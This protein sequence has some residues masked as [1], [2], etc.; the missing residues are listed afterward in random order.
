MHQRGEVGRSVAGV[1][2]RCAAAVLFWGVLLLGGVT[3]PASAQD[4]FPDTAPV[5]DKDILEEIRR[6]AEISDDTGEEEDIDEL[7]RLFKEGERAYT[8]GRFQDAVEFFAAVKDQTT[9]RGII[10]ALFW[11]MATCYNRMG[12]DDLERIYWR[13]FLKYGPSEKDARVARTRLAALRGAPG[14]SPEDEAPTPDVGPEPG[15]A[16]GGQAPPPAPAEGPEPER[17]TG[18]DFWGGP[19][20]QPE[21]PPATDDEPFPAGLEY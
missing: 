14:P 12:K 15:P 7:R 3:T 11:N 19:E 10:R 6:L 21:P 18:P 8:D 17:A 13:L 9:R 4:D 16:A 5:W 1:A 20:P 2:S